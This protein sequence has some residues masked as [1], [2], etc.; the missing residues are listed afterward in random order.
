M[1]WFFSLDIIVSFSFIQE[2]L[3]IDSPDKREILA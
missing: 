2:K 1:Y 3:E